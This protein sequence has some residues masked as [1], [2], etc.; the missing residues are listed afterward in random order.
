MA[1]HVSCIYLYAEESQKGNDDNTVRQYI[2][3]IIHKWCARG[4]HLSYR[5]RS[6]VIRNKRETFNENRYLLP[7]RQ[8]LKI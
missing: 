5:F 4:T 8:Q 2:L 1:V 7:S 6:S 3:V